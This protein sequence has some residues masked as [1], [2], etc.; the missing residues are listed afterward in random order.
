LKYFSI[1]TAAL[2]GFEVL[3]LH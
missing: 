3:E 1:I 2:I